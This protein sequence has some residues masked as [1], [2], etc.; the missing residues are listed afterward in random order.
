MRANAFAAS[1][2]T[3]GLRSS[4]KLGSMAMA[5]S[6][7]GV[8]RQA[9]ARVAGSGWRKPRCSGFLGENTAKRRRGTRRLDKTGAGDDALDDDA[10]DRGG[11][12]GAAN[13]GHCLQGGGLLGDGVMLAEAFEAAAQRVQCRNGGAPLPGPGLGRWIGWRPEWKRSG[14]RRSVM[15]RRLVIRTRDW[16]GGW[17]RVLRSRPSR[18]PRT[19]RVAALRAGWAS[20][21]RR[22]PARSPSP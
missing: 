9:F 1:V 20:G 3:P 17:V 13:L 21:E 5:G 2:A 7:R 14:R 12:V 6:V 15:R 18:G 11:G 16:V 10:A 22:V 4:S 8:Q 19:D